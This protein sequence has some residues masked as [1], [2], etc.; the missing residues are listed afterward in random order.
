MVWSN[1]SYLT[2]QALKSGV[3][4]FINLLDFT[5]TLDTNE[6]GYVDGKYI[7]IQ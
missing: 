3:Y 1:K 6:R 7:A 5:Q 2:F 4:E